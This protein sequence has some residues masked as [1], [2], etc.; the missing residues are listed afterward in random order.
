MVDQ[1][2]QQPIITPTSTL[3]P[4]TAPAPNPDLIPDLN[5]TS[6]PTKTFVAVPP[7]GPPPAPAPNQI[8]VS[9][10]SQ[11]LATSTAIFTPTAPTHNPTQYT[12]TAPNVDAN[13]YQSQ[14]PMGSQAIPTVPPST[15]ATP[16]VFDSLDRMTNDFFTDCKIPPLESSQSKDLP[17]I[18]KLAR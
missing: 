4:A 6:A 9:T 1:S 12:E 8:P 11:S 10:P 15:P 5:P 3:A 7:A 18:K 2:Q 13:L 16:S 17:G 14:S